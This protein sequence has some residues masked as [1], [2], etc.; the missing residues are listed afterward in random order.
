M[1]LKKNPLTLYLNDQE[2]VTMMTINDFPE[3]L[4]LGYLLNQNMITKTTK[5]ES[6]EYYA[7][8]K[9]VVVRTKKSTNFEAKLKKKDHY[10][11]LCSR[12]SVR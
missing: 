10:L 1:L 11:R 3:Y 6:V 9:T 8:I 12:N 2:I 7:D 4:A 5:I